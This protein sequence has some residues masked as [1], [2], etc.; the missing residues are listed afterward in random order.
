MRLVAM[1]FLLAVGLAMAAPVAAQQVKDVAFKAGH[2]TAL[3]TGMLT[4]SQ[5]VDYRLALTTGGPVQISLRRNNGDIDSGLHFLLISPAGDT[6]YDSSTS[7][8][9]AMI[10]LAKPGT[11]TIRVHLSADKADG[12]ETMEYDM[13]VTVP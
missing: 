7:D 1:T 12:G 11:Y 4:G 5:H 9:R 10:D 13:D 3:E 6:V 8:N 2:K